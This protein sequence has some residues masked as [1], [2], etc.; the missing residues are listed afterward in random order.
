MLKRFFSKDGGEI[1]WSIIF[2]VMMLALIGLASLYVAGTH[3]AG[4]NV[5]RMVVLQLAYYIVGI[6]GVAILMQFDSEQLW[7]I[8]PY[9]FGVGML[10]MVAVLF[11]YSKAYYE[12][13]G[14]KWF[15]IGPVTF[16]PAEI[17]KPAFIIML[18]RVITDHNIANPT[19]TMKSDWRLLLKIMLWTVPVLIVNG[20]DFGTNL[21][22]IAVV[23]GMTLVSG[24]SWLILGP[25]IAFV[26]ALGS[27]AILLVTQTWGR[28]MLENIG[29]KAYQ[30]TRID[31]W[32]NPQNDTSN[33]AYQLWQS[34]KAI[35]S[36]GI[37][38]TGF[39]VSHVDVPVRESDMIFS[40]IGENF[41]FVGGVLLLILYFLLI[42]QIIQVVFDSS[43]QFYAYI[44]TGVV[45][46]LLF[47]I[48]ENIGMN[49]GLVPLTG[50]PLPFIS[51]GGSALIGNM[52]GIGL[53]MSMRYH[54]KS[55]SLS[56]RE[57][58]S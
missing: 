6:I 46:M 25:I 42:Y 20:S 34:I 9:A 30:F 24:L 22:F 15:A 23:F 55:F 47:H 49:I 32:L 12:S 43:N 27:V 35:G 3:D 2:V 53:I 45:M 57:G 36:G 28:H 38:G 18:A 26:G 29:F 44:A 14:G 13:T 5:I 19:H 56:E 54:N 21:V 4:V 39:N 48:F 33:G 41:G 7:R 10:L 16:Q 58:F 1:D 17:M 52:I 8:A 37:T 51:Q 11:F 31:A 40:V 50:I